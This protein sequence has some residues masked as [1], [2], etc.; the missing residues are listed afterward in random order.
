MEIEKITEQGSLATMKAEIYNLILAQSCRYTSRSEVKAPRPLKLVKQA[1]IEIKPDVKTIAKPEVVEIKPELKVVKKFYND[2]TVDVKFDENVR[3]YRR[4]EKDPKL[5][6]K[7]LQLFANSRCYLK[8]LEYAVQK[9]FEIHVSIDF[10]KQNF[11]KV[12]TDKPQSVLQASISGAILG[13]WNISGVADAKFMKEIV[14]ES[15]LKA[16]FPRIYK[17]IQYK[18]P[19]EENPK[20]ILD[21]SGGHLIPL[22]SII[23]ANN[24]KDQHID[25][26]C[27]LANLDISAIPIINQ[28]VDL[29]T[30]ISA[31]PFV[32]FSQTVKKI[33]PTLDL[34]TLELKSQTGAEVLEYFQNAYRD[35]IEPMQIQFNASFEV[36]PLASRFIWDGVNDVTA[37][38]MLIYNEE[39]FKIAKDFLIE[40]FKLN[41]KDTSVQLN[42]YEILRDGVE[43][44][45]YDLRT[46]KKERLVRTFINRDFRDVENYFKYMFITKVLKSLNL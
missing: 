29:E 34:V 46:K 22:E 35:K 26:E 42:T 20:H 44:Y 39:T 32:Y 14:S 21:C 1:E 13:I 27:I 33:K 17:K 2:Y 41:F 3:T 5:E 30:S 6:E 8:A 31:N 43:L 19:K 28:S 40:Y 7:A 16:L 45:K 25:T 11:K 24:E 18:H 12:S 4:K 38:N 9:Q 10:L 36:A 23:A 37:S 15:L